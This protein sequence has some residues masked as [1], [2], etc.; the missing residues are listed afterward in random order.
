MT[1]RH[2]LAYV[3]RRLL[4]LVL[5][6]IVISFT[7]FSLLFVAPGSPEQVLLGTRPASP[8][9]IAAIR[10]EHH[11]DDPFL[12]QYARWA[13][14]A[15]RLDFG[16]S[17]RTGEP[18]TTALEGRL[19]VT[20]RLGALA[21]ALT[22]LAGI[23][24]GMLAA[25]KRR[26]IVDRVV[27]GLS[28]VGVSA[29]AFATGILLL[30]L[31]A[32]RLDWFPVFGQGE[33]FIGGLHHLALPAI[34]LALTAVALVIKLTR[35][36]MISALEQDYVVF[37][38]ARGISRPRILVRYALRNALVPIVTAGGLILAYMLVGAVLVEST[39][40]LPG[41]GS[42]LVDS[43]TGKDLPMVQGLAVISAAVVVFVNL[44]VDLLYFAVDPRIAHGQA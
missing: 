29:P 34:A 21:F 43:V 40:A 16:R 20:L 22:M 19:G 9:A 6:L 7:V 12:L 3:G 4:A 2:L 14:D 33:G 27:V 10:A 17:I 5:L 31:F 1:R 30:Y 25:V 11:L 39:F 28:V 37:A 8:G 42:L 44:A 13:R 23:P 36:G 35:A 15:V 41:A 24:L 26:T 38:R 32:V 18:V